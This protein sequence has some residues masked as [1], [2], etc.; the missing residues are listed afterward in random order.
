MDPPR[1]QYSLRTW[2]H[3]TVNCTER[4]PVGGC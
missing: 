4:G 3:S 1:C 2:V